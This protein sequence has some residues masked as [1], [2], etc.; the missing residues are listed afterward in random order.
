MWPMI[1]V[2]VAVLALAIG[3]LLGRAERASEMA[4]R[5][6]RLVVLTNELLAGNAA[7]SRGSKSVMDRLD[8]VRAEL[9]RLLD[10]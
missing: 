1:A 6:R 2:A 3:F 10:A 9:S 7:L 4:R 5:N 8:L